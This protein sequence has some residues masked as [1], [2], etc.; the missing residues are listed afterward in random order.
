VERKPPNPV[1]KSFLVCRR[2]FLDSYT[3]EYLLLGPQHEIV[4]TSY[5][6]VVP[7]ALF[8]RWTSVQGVYDLQVQLQ[9]LEGNVLWRENQLPP[10]EC[11]DPLR[12]TILTL[13]ALHVYFPRPG[14]YEFVLLANDEEVVRDVFW[15]HLPQPPTA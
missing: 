7:L 4:A 8:A 5:P 13:H 14:K 12:V 1:S 3:K 15:A 10:L 6:I 2:I 9:D 11:Q